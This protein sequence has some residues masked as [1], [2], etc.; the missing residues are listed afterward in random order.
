MTMAL[1]FNDITLTPIPH[2]NSL[3]IRAVELARALGY[4]DDSIVSRLYRKHADEFSPEMTQ[5]IGISAED[6]NGLLGSAGRC[7][8]FSL[9]GCHLLAMFARTPV[10]KAFRKWVLDV[11]EQYGDRV[12]VEPASLPDESPSFPGSVSVTPSTV[13]D[14]K[15]LRALVNA[16]AHVSAQPF[17]VCWTQLKAAFRLTDIRDLPQE[18]IP[19][20][21]AWVQAKIDALSA[22]SVPART[23][24]LPASSIY[25][26]RVKALTDLEKRFMEF[27]I[28]TRT[29]LSALNAEYTRLNQGAYA[30]MLGMIPTMDFAARD[31]LIEALTSQSYDAYNLIDEGLHCMGR[32]I[33][34]A[35]AA[36]RVLSGRS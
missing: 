15:P 8:I 34:A 21:L 23:T 25:A 32:V 27:S 1:T 11:I 10:A 7:R 3:W 20:A 14:R 30:A 36:N 6:Q 28:E 26:D 19:D 9:R 33:I 24:A 4:S 17:N 35:R 31:R 22:V 13:E 2:Q 16:W 5:L 12:P 29:R 18:W